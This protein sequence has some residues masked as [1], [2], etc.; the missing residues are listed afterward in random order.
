MKKVFFATVYIF[1][2][3]F[4]M[5]A[6]ADYIVQPYYQDSGY[7]FKH[8]GYIWS[9]LDMGNGIDTTV[10]DFTFKVTATTTPYTNDYNLRFY[11]FSDSLLTTLV[12]CKNNGTNIGTDGV[13][14][15]S[16]NEN[17]N[18]GG[19]VK[20]TSFQNNSGTPINWKTDPTQY[21]VV[22]LHL[23]SSPSNHYEKIAG[24]NAVSEGI[25]NCYAPD[26]VGQCDDN[27]KLQ[28]FRLNAS[29]DPTGTIITPVENSIHQDFSTWYINLKNFP[30]ASTTRSVY[31]HYGHTSNADTFQ[32]V[33]AQS[34]ISKS[35]IDQSIGVW[36]RNQL[37]NA[38]WY[39]YFTVYDGNIF[40]YQST[41]TSFRISSTSTPQD[42][43]TI[44]DHLIPSLATSSP[45]SYLDYIN[46]CNPFNFDIKLCITGLFIPTPSQ[47]SEIVNNF[48]NGFL[49]RWPWGYV[50]R[51]VAIMNDTAHT[52]LPK[53]DF[54][55]P[56]DKGLPQGIAGRNVQVS[57]FDAFASSSPLT[58]AESY[59]GTTFL[60]AFMPWWRTV[61]LFLFGMGILHL[62]I[63][64]RVDMGRYRGKPMYMHENRNPNKAGYAKLHKKI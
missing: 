47:I 53:I 28:F 52:N 34:Y 10:S 12:S 4:V 9:Y 48:T 39:A 30:I 45:A 57:I 51:A 11:C 16:T 22:Q 56:A 64:F 8:G 63:N 19:F 60:E 5:S 21:I 49:T 54:T 40:E 43:P 26:Y 38:K 18:S 6:K 46:Y 33:F 41:T 23:N 62:L 25:T 15:S 3:V 42:I 55:F 32:D 31:V 36:K 17:P 27:V 7:D 24:T 37:D 50:T 2:F 29:G 44:P 20:F 14:Y 61:V 35:I 58:V 59:D 13:V 1:S